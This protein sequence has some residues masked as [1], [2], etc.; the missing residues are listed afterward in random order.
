MR[1]D[2]DSIN[3]R[4]LKAKN[5]K[6]IVG[7]ILV[8]IIYNILLIVISEIDGMKKFNI[9]GYQSYIIISNSM[10]PELSEEDV[11]IVKQIEEDKIKINDIITY[12]KDGKSITHRVIGITEIDGHK[13]FKTK[14]DNNSLEDLESINYEQ[15]RGKVIFKIPLLGKIIQF[16]KDQI[17]I[18]IIILICLIAFLLNMQ[19]RDKQ[20]IRKRKKEL[21]KYKYTNN[22]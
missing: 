11:V 6:I 15:I 3:K 19:K 13:E 1:Y 10:Q 12:I 5:L 8:V 20:E 4:K 16:M 22:S 7:I 21:E 14:G 9:F 18:L 17:I 2:I